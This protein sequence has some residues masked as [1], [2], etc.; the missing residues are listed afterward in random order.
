MQKSSLRNRP[1]GGGAGPRHLSAAARAAA[2]RAAKADDERGAVRSPAPEPGAGPALPAE[3]PEAPAA[4]EDSVAESAADSAAEPITEPIT[5]PVADSAAEPRPASGTAG[6]RNSVIS[7]VLAVLVVAGLVAG[8]LLANAYRHD[9]AT[10]RARVQALAAARTAAP[11]VLSYD[12]RHLSKDFAAALTHLTGPFRAEYRKTTA[13]VVTPT[14]TQYH[15]VVKAT[16]ASPPGG[17]QAA[18]VVSA[19]PGKVVVLLF[20]NQTT[21]STKLDAPRVDLN[22]VRMTLT[23][24]AAGWKVSAVDAL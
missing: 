1:G 12:Y 16:V 11:V 10:R 24:T 14:A 3:E 17:Q 2:K 20:M 8:A 9:E 23:H 4:V 5:E 6:R 22:R 7:A 19:S 15:G 18:S 13:T 21:Q